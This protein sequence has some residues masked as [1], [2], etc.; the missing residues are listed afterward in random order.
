G[1]R[2]LPRID[3]GHDA[4]VSSLL[5][6]C[7]TWHVRYP[8]SVVR[9]PQNGRLRSPRTTENGVRRTSC[10]FPLLGPEPQNQRLLCYPVETELGEN[11][12][13]RM[14]NAKCRITRA[15]G[16]RHFYILH[17]A[18]CICYLPTICNARKPCSPPPFY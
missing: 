14:Q 17:S 2:S 1:S 18:F 16:P 9:C 13:C 8:L 10:C 7:L 5:E 3:V 12:E 15:G 4:D 6:R 11:R